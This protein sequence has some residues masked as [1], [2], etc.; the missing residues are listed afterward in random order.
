MRTIGL[1]VS[2]TAAG[3]ADGGYD[4]TMVVPFAVGIDVSEASDPRSDTLR[5]GAAATYVVW[6]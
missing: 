1:E 4:R 2:L 5:R 3:L 6:L